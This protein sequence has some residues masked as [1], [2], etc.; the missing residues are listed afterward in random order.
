MG[1]TLDRRA[2]SLLAIGHMLNDVNQGAVPA[3][4]PFLVTDQGLTYA[5]AS[6]VVLAVTLVSGVTQPL[7]GLYSDRH[8]ITWLIPVGML[9]GG[10]GIALSGV[11]TDY[12]GIIACMLVSGAGVAAFHPESYRFAN[13]VSGASRAAG[14]SVF[15]VGGSLGFAL[16]PI[17]LTGAVLLFGLPGTLVLLFP[18][19]IF[20][21]ILFI[22]LNQIAKYRPTS[23]QLQDTS[24]VNPTNWRAFSGVVAVIVL[25]TIVQYGMLTFIPLYLHQ[26]RL[27]PIGEANSA[28]VLIALAGAVGTLVAGKLADHLGYKRMLVVVL[29]LISPALFLFLQTTG[30]ASLVMLAAAGMATSASFTIAVVLGQNFSESNLGVATGITTGF[31]I[32]LGGLSSPL[33]GRMADTVGLLPVLTLLAFI[34]LAATL[35]A[36][37]L[38]AVNHVQALPQVNTDSVDIAP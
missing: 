33:L 38:P 35:I 14:M 1:H 22:N 36:L 2:L 31:A 11:V 15:T 28:L 3:L 24:Q 21:V 20:A 5:A 23:E 34:P 26:V 29:L 13:Y 17:L 10:L 8:P 32:G 37:A 25:R 9:L 16:G 19:A 27:V 18:A 4:L 30:V 6:G 12:W 7:L